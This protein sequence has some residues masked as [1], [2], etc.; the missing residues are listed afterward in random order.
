MNKN[1]TSK[2]LALKAEAVDVTSLRVQSMGKSPTGPGVPTRDEASRK[3]PDGAA[4][5]RWTETGLQKRRRQ[6][7]KLT[8]DR[9][10]RRTRIRLLE[11][12][13]PLRARRNTFA[14]TASSYRGNAL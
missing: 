10:N 6:R 13:S 2:Y 5:A 14:V 12:R 4:I 8:S 11:T 3:S 7:G 9:L 1:I